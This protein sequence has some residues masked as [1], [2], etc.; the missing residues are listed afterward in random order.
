MESGAGSEGGL[1]KG[2]LVAIGRSGGGRKR[3]RT[4]GLSSLRITRRSGGH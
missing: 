1:F 4:H 3:L 2:L